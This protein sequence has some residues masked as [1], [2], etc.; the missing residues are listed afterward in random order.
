MAMGL[1]SEL[2][3]RA[4]RV[5]QKALERLFVN[6]RRAERVAQAIGAVQRG[7]KSFDEKQGAVMHQLSF[8]TK[9]DYKEISRRLGSLHRR[10]QALAGK[11]SD[12]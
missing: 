8:A 5:S 10:V 9:S 6:E 2:K 11:M 3:R 1:S 4:A 7:K 12:L